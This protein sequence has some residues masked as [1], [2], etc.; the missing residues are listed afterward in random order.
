MVVKSLRLSQQRMSKLKNLE[1]FLSFIS[2]SSFQVDD[3]NYGQG[4]SDRLFLNS[5]V[6]SLH[7]SIHSMSVIVI[8]ECRDS[9]MQSLYVIY[10]KT[11]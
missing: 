2:F 6:T 9:L 4:V 1:N 5:A 8:A 11:D 3:P 7:N 10:L